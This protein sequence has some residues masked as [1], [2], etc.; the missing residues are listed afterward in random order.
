MT[1]HEETELLAYFLWQERG[2]PWGSP[3]VDWFR[4]E[5]QLEEPQVED[6]EQ[7]RSEEPVLV[8]VARR[9]GS[10]LGTVTYWRPENFKL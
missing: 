1:R 8:A 7:S 3:E 2:C 6:H 4:A 5:R 9:L 10:V